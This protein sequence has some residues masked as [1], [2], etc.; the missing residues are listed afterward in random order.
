M[1]DRKIELPSVYPDKAA[2]IPAASEARVERQRSI[3]QPDHRANILAELSQYQG[4]VDEDA[5]IVLPHLERPP[6]KVGALAAIRVWLVGPA[7]TDEPQVA[8]RRPGQCR[9]VMRIVRDCLPDQ[10]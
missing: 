8:D 4:G 1:F 3:D 10:A 5:R 7:I 9:P 6:G 2:P